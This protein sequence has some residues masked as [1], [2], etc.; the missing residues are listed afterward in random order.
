MRE[1]LDLASDHAGAKKRKTRAPPEPCVVEHDVTATVS[2][3]IVDELNALVL[4][5]AEEPD[6]KRRFMEGL[7]AR[8]RGAMGYDTKDA[9]NLHVLIVTDPALD[10]ADECQKVR[11]LLSTH[12]ASDDNHCNG[13]QLLH[14]E[15]VVVIRLDLFHCTDSARSHVKGWPL[16]GA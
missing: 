1:I 7:F 12:S 16:R 4:R 6:R 14:L 2:S 8:L 5:L 11:T 9:A 3:G 13:L 10:C 15:L